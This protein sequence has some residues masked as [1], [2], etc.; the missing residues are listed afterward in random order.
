MPINTV[1]HEKRKQLEL[2]QE[3]VAAYLGVTAPAVNKWEKGSTYPDITLLPSLARLLKTDLNTLLCFQEEP[4]QQEIQYF[5]KQALKLIQEEDLDAG[6][7][8]MKQK[9]QEYP[10][11]EALIHSFAILLDS[12]LIFSVLTQ[13]EKK[14]YEA[15]LLD[16]YERVASGDDEKLRTNAAAMLA[17]KHMLRK[18]YEKAQ[19]MID[20][21]PE[22]NILDKHTFQADL[23]LFQREHLEDASKL[24]QRKLLSMLMDMNGILL[25]MA[26]IELASGND[27]K[28]E[29]ISDITKNLVKAMDLWDYYAYIVPLEIALARKD[30]SESLRLMDELF[31]SIDHTWNMQTSPLYDLL[32]N[33]A[34]ANNP[35]MMLPPLIANLEHAPEY[36]F[37]R[38][39]ERFQRLI[40]KY[41]T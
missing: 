18:E 41:R 8:M 20:L 6:F 9:I 1:I 19:E 34:A 4:S 11:C 13:T 2:T 21:M 15:E 28:A 40:E 22:Y 25:R 7:Q 32:G 38:E 33:P 29:Q 30:V 26:K 3:Q 24:L 36:D 39:D 17:S 16:W 5:C 31:S 37:L 12:S 10:H 35:S 23:Y 14:K 27:R